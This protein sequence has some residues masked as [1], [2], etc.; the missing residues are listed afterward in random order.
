MK[1]WR[2]GNCFVSVLHTSLCLL[3]G[4]D[5]SRRLLFKGL[6]TSVSSVIDPLGRGAST[7]VVMHLSNNSMNAAFRADVAAKEGNQDRALGLTLT[8]A[9]FLLLL[10]VGLDFVRAWSVAMAL[11]A[12]HVILNAMAMRV[13]ALKTLNDVRLKIILEAWEGGEQDASCLSP[14]EVAQREPVLGFSFFQRENW[15]LFM[16][17]AAERLDEAAQAS[18]AT[19]GARYALSATNGQLLCALH[20]DATAGDQLRAMLHAILAK[21][22]LGTREDVDDMRATAHI[23]AARQQCERLF[24]RLETALERAGWQ[25]NVMFC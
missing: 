13:L 14:D 23:A 19:Q 9:R 5:P 17:A 7:A 15:P 12:F 6:G 3:Q 24:P 10:W 2:V 16:G 4:M 8:V 1:N 18:L 25:L 21:K 11:S 20:S 22:R